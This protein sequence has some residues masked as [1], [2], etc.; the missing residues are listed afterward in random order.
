MSLELLPPP[1]DYAIELRDGGEVLL[2]QSFDVDFELVQGIG[3][4]GDLFPPLEPRTEVMV[5]FIM[6]WADGATSI[7]LVNNGTTLD[8]TLGC[9][10][11]PERQHR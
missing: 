10:G 6:P 2:S 5:S 1:G 8:E 11:R 3:I 9:C 7:A 4:S